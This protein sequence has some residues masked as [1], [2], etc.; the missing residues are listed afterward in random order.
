MRTSSLV[1][2][3]YPGSR[4]RHL[5]NF[6]Y[7]GSCKRIVVC[8]IQKYMVIGSILTRVIDV[9]VNSISH[10]SQ[11]RQSQKLL[12]FLLRYPDLSILC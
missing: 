1:C 7:I 4:N 12:C 2:G 6:A 9:I 3:V 10:L 8:H 5:H 11:Q